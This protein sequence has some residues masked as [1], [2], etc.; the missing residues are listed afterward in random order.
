M[1]P[2]PTI[3]PNFM[4]P[5]AAATLVTTPRDYGVFMTQLLTGSLA[6]VAPRA[7]SRRLMFTSHTPINSALSWGLGLGQETH[8][9]DNYSWHWGDNG[10]WKNFM[11]VHPATRSGIALFTNGSRGLNLASRVMTAATGSEHEA[12]LWL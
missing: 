9:G 3:L 5:N 12:F 1:T 10:S 2:A 8:G 7:E 6:A 4:I 11:L